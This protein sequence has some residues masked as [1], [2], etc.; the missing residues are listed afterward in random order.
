MRKYRLVLPIADFVTDFGF[1][2]SVQR[3]DLQN[4]AVHIFELKMKMDNSSPTSA[5][6]KNEVV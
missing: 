2:F 4:I 3:S 6:P 1:T 5:I